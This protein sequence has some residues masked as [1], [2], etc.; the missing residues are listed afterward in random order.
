[1]FPDAGAPVVSVAAIS[2]VTKKEYSYASRKK[3]D[4]CLTYTVD[5]YIF[6]NQ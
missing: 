3:K 5:F 2:K 1:L 4:I 6:G